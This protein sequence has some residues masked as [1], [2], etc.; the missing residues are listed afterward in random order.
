MTRR[1]IC[2]AQLTVVRVTITS[3]ECAA[4]L[5]GSTGIPSRFAEQ[6]ACPARGNDGHNDGCGRA[7]GGQRR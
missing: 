7:G 3:A 5:Q 4:T 6:Q 2:T 1:L